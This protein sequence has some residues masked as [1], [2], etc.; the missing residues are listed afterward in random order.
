MWYLLTM[1]AAAMHARAHDCDVPHLEMG[2]MDSAGAHISRHEP[3]RGVARRRTKASHHALQV[4]RR[5]HAHGVARGQ[6]SHKHHDGEERGGWDGEERGRPEPGPH[7]SAL[8]NV[9]V[10]S[11]WEWAP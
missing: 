7:A 9:A 8:G 2:H 10:A 11:E 3:R 6:Y 4:L 5:R 1:I